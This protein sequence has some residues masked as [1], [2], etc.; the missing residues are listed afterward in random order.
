LYRCVSLWHIHICL[1]CILTAFI[2]SFSLIFPSPLFTIISIGFIVQFSYTYTKYIDHICPSSPFPF[3]L[4][5]VPTHGQD[6]F[7]LPALH[8]FKWLMIV[9]GVFT[10]VFHKCKHYTLIRLT[11]C[12]IYSFSITLQPYYSTTFSAFQYTI[13]IH[14]FD[15]FQYY[16]LSITLFSSPTSPESPPTDPLLQ[17]CSIYLS[18]YL[19]IHMYIRLYM[20]LCVHLSFRS[21]FYIWGKRWDLCPIEPCLL[22]LTLGCQF[23]HCL[24]TT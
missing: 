12:I 6:Q 13:F 23:I 11:P 19:Q 7:Y 24:H 18:I 1:Q 20:D 8:F 3:T 9:Q 2:P 21:S 16:S 17:S 5:L 14:R 4:P 15:V 10:M 22:C